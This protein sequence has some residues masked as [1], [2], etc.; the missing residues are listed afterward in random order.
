MK[1]KPLA[2]RLSLNACLW[3]CRGGTTPR[4]AFAAT[5]V[6]GTAPTRSLL[7]GVSSTCFL[8]S[9]SNGNHKE[10]V[11][12]NTRLAD[13]ADASSSSS[14]ASS[15][16]RYRLLDERWCF[17]GPVD[18]GY[19]R[20]GKKLGFPTA[21]LPSSL[22]QNALSNVPNGVYFGWAVLEDRTNNNN[23][24]GRG[25]HKAVVNVGVSPTFEGAEN[26]EKIIEAH[27]AV[28]GKQGLS[29]FY[30]E[31]MRLQLDAFMRP[32]RKFP[33]FPELMAQITADVQDAKAA[34]D[35]EPFA[36][37]GSS[38]FL[39]QTTDKAW[40]GSGG[41]DETASWDKTTMKEFL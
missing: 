11:S 7:G 38:D 22:F 29:D 10:D 17:R 24:G 32:E 8:S 5:F 13:T 23:G 35:T 15:D 33:S 20:G 41:G 26:P 40:V 21:N 36:S 34:L 14:S 4:G 18:R 16:P 9:S 12:G 28:E 1:W 31:T 6:R 25:P 37:F 3:V 30:G 2:S 39:V 27:L 19:G